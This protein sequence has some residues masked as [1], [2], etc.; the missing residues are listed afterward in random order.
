MTSVS[1]RFG[2]EG[3]GQPD[4]TRVLAAPVFDDSQGHGL[5][6]PHFGPEGKA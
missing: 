1:D 4:R 3:D 5:E 2:G 6:R